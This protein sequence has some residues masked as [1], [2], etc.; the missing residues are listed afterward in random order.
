M[1]RV[2]FDP[3]AREELDAAA[4]HYEREYEGRGQRFYS[5]VERAVRAASASP[6]AGPRFPGLAEELE[7]RRRIVPGFPFVVAYRTQ[8]DE[9]RIVAVIH[10]RRRPGYWRGRIVKQD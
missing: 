2:S 3:L 10:T 5:A 7:V 6:L 1:N 8:A 9:L 4:E